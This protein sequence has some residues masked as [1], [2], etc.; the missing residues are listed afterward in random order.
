MDTRIQ[1]DVWP[2]FV[3]AWHVA[4]ASL[5]YEPSADYFSRSRRRSTA[6]WRRW[7]ADDRC[8]HLLMGALVGECTGLCSLLVIRYIISFLAP[9]AC[10]AMY[11]L[12]G[13][14]LTPA[15]MARHPAASWILSVFRSSTARLSPC[16]SCERTQ[17][18]TKLTR[19]AVFTTQQLATAVNDSPLAIMSTL[20]RSPAWWLF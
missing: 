7:T 18:A 17:R 16:L 5:N 1:S 8:Q 20:A 19:V 15:A 10:C 11:S 2:I 12:Y 13:F 4:I 14:H 3:S 6:L 9:L